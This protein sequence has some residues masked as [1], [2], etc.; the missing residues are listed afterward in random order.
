VNTPRLRWVLF[1]L[2]LALAA[3]ADLEEAERS[4]REGRFEEA[5]ARFG[6]ALREPGQKKK[7][8]ILHDM[9][10]CAFRLNRP[11]EALHHYLRAEKRLP[12]DPE[13]AFNRRMAEKRLRLDAAD[14]A[15]SAGHLL[16][17]FTPGAWL[18]L[19]SG[20]LALGLVGLVLARERRRRGLRAAAALVSLLALASAARL[21]VAEFV[22]GPAAGI[23]LAR[24]IVLL[25]EP[26]AGAEVT[27]TLR[28]GDRVRV[29]MTSGAYLRIASGEKS[30]WSERESVGVID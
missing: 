20:F 29:G 23:V 11:A 27:G 7:G 15:P 19:S 18:A 3:P 12:N 10:N 13:V 16:L 6:S 24:E 17:A 30:G 25:A 14:V 22:P 2:A 28:A 9:G 8:A 5:L 26:A 1:A 21:A 4:Y